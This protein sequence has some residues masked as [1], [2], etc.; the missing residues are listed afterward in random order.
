MIS[1]HDCRVT[2]DV[3]KLPTCQE[4]FTELCCHYF[5]KECTATG[6]KNIASLTQV[7]R[8]LFWLDND[9]CWQL[10]A[11]GICH[12]FLTDQVTPIGDLVSKS[13]GDSFAESPKALKTLHQ[14]V[15]FV[16][17]RLL[18]TICPN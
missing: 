13:F 12:T 6:C 5:S 18:R 8:C 7:L 14:I 10:F 2:C 17:N 15:E 1:V 4:I 11:R 16:E 3:M 9:Q